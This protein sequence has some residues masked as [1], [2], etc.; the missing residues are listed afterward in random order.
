MYVYQFQTKHFNQCFQVWILPVHR[1]ENS[2]VWL[3]LQQVIGDVIPF[4]PF[5]FGSVVFEIVEK[6]Y[7]DSIV[8]Y[9][10]DFALPI[11][12][13]SQVREK[14]NTSFRQC[15]K[16]TFIETSVLST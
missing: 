15:R 12:G 16:A 14:N 7:L 8:A 3:D 6:L 1:L 10:S 13:R 4:F 11:V 5:A 2:L 9:H